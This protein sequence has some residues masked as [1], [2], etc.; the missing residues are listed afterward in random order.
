VASTEGQSFIALASPS[1]TFILVNQ[2]RRPLQ[3]G[4]KGEARIVVGRRRL[5]EYAFEPIRQL[6][7]NM[8][9]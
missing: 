5:I 2:A 6:R 4:M 1:Q 7:E 3:V 9:R 8:G